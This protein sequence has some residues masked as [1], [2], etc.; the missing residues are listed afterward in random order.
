MKL[1]AVYVCKGTQRVYQHHLDTQTGFY[2]CVTI[3]MP[4]SICIV[5]FAVTMAFVATTQRSL[6]HSELVAPTK[7]AASQSILLSSIVE[8]FNNTNILTVS[9]LCLNNVRQ[10][11]IS[12]AK[13]LAKHAR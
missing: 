5:T 3:F 4:R 11:P 9:I 7:K 2:K 6:N 8:T 12:H 13:P 1:H 10:R